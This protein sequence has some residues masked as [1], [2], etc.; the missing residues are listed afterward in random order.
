MVVNFSHVAKDIDQLFKSAMYISNVYD[1]DKNLEIVQKCSFGGLSAEKLSS[2]AVHIDGDDW[3]KEQHSDAVWR[4][5]SD[6]AR[7]LL[8]QWSQEAKNNKKVKP[9]S[10]VKGTLEQ[11]LKS[12]N[13]GEITRKQL[14]DNMLAGEAH[15]QTAYPSNFSKFIKATQYRPAKNMISKCRSAL[16][17]TENDS[18]RIAMNEEYIKMANSMS[19]EQIFKS[20]EE[21][22][23]YGLDFKVEKLAFEKENKIVCDREVE[24]KSNELE[25]LKAKDK[26]PI[27]IHELDERKAILNQQPRV[28]PIVPTLQAQRNLSVNQ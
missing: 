28:E 11:A 16:G 15:L 5:Q 14:L 27:S 10:R 3:A 25:A 7:K 9:G 2:F 26:E 4:K 6:K 1:N 22:M 17:L 13:K 23:S 24:R 8:S 18:L 21:R 19:K 20:V 12:F